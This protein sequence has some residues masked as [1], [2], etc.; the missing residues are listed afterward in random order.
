MNLKPI[1]AQFCTR[2]KFFTV[3][4]GQVFSFCNLVFYK[5]IFIISR[6]LSYLI[7]DKGLSDLPQSPSS[8]C[9][10]WSTSA[11]LFA[12]GNPFGT[13]M[14]LITPKCFEN[15]WKYFSYL[16]THSPTQPS[17]HW[18]CTVQINFV[19]SHIGRIRDLAHLGKTWPRFQL[20]KYTAY[21]CAFR[22]I[23]A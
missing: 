5:I 2:H 13:L 7:Y 18:S 14:Q 4:P 8:S 16:A 6:W 9:L 1:S 20:I 11:S 17:S 3:K 21:E 19:P 10:S 15:S 12:A 22:W 23:C